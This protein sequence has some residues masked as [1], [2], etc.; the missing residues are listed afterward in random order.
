L[1]ERHKAFMTN[2]LID[3]TT[4][5]GIAA[6][7]STK[8]VMFDGFIRD[9]VNDDATSKPFCYS[10]FARVDV[11]KTGLAGLEAEKL[12]DC[13]FFTYAMPRGFALYLIP[14][15][16]TGN[17]SRQ[18]AAT[19]RNNCSTAVQIKYAAKRISMSCF[20]LTQQLTGDEQPNVNQL[21]IDMCV[22]DALSM[23]DK[24]EERV[25]DSK[26]VYTSDAQKNKQEK[27]LSNSLKQIAKQQVN[28]NN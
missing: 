4:K 18:L 6:M 14:S 28:Q 20:P 11:E 12:R 13:V 10:N 26:G 27:R 19:I 21:N 7:N 25:K 8:L 16:P 5:E 9:L 17:I 1:Q 2:L 22:T 23:L 3:H 15:D 24:A